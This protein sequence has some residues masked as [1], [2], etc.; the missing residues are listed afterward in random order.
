M[1]VGTN[2]PWTS[3][4]LEEL[5]HRVIVANPRKLRAI[6]QNDRKCDRKD[7]EMLAKLARADES[8]LHPVKHGSEKAQ[9]D[10]SGE[11]DKQLRIT[12]ASDSY[13]RRLLVEETDMTILEQERK[14]LER[15]RCTAGTIAR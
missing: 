4:Y 1:E 15:S 9:R 7:A 2:S 6:Y 10:Q 3:R 8:L 14:D 12:K 11:T 5:G 13:L